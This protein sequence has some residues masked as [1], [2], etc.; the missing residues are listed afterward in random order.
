M[1]EISELFKRNK[2]SNDSFAWGTSVTL[3]SK[4]GA[5]HSV[6]QTVFSMFKLAD[7]ELWLHLN[8]MGFNEM[9]WDLHERR[10][11]QVKRMENA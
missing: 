3:R 10:D 11:Y 1:G 7:A 8:Q 6:N 5:H 4:N 2:I 9:A